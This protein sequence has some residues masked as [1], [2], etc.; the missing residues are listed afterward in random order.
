FCTNQA[1]GCCSRTWHIL[2][3][4][5]HSM[6][7]HAEQSTSVWMNTAS[8]PTE[9]PLTRDERA[10]V[11]VVGAGIAGLS[12]AYLLARAGKSV[13]VLDNELDAARRAGL[14]DVEMVTRAP[15]GSFD[16]GRCLRFPRQG[17]FHPLK[18]LAGLARAIERVGGRI[19]TGT[20]AKGIEGGPEAKVGTERG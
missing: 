13:V 20:H 10:D 12:T 19:Y 2:A 17:Q 4:R 8:L 1:D 9:Q 11:C 16:T 14:R 6:K 3:Q 5:N 7:P 15:L 18:Y